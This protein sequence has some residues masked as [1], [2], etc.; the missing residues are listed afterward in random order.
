MREVRDKG[1]GS[2]HVYSQR[3]PLASRSCVVNT[4]E[5]RWRGGGFSPPRVRTS[6]LRHGSYPQFLQKHLPFVYICTLCTCTLA[7]DGI[8]PIGLKSSTISAAWRFGSPARLRRERHVSTTQETRVEGKN[9]RR[10]RHASTS[11][12]GKLSTGPDRPDTEV[13]Q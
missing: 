10:K 4:C 3:K 13:N 12:P 6:G 2:F 8:G 11:G 1:W 5:N 7:N 9:P